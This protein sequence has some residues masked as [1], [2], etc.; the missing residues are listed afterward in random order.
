MACEGARASQC[1]VCG[2]GTAPSALLAPL[3]FVTC[4]GCG[5]TFR[6]DRVDEDVHAIYES[7]AYTEVRHPEYSDAG[8]LHDRRRQAQ[9]RLDFIAP[10]AR[11]GR[12]LDVGAAGGAFVEQALARGFDA[13][14]IEPTPEFAAFAR[15]SLGVPV[16]ATT[17]EHADLPAASLDVATMWHVLEH[18]PDPVGVLALLHRALRP[19]GIVAI[20]VP[21]AAGHLARSQGRAWASLE[22][23]VHVNQFGPRSLRVALERAGF[24][25]IELGTVTITP[26]LSPLERLRPGEIV[27]RLRGLL[28]LRT[29]SSSHPDGHELLRCAAQRP[30]SARS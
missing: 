22:P 29:P 14:G 17:V 11:G 6:E 9:V 27:H 21:N 26:Y 24:D 15:E 2:A 30:A 4:V 7:G 3:P 19:G 1:R 18:V 10:H 28:A 23:E 25:V 8:T 20:E 12:L 5:F 13:E 16:R